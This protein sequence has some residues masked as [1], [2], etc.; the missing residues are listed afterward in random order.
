MSHTTRLSLGRTFYVIWIFYFLSFIASYA[1]LPTIPLHLRELG[2]SVKESGRFTTA[3]MLGAGFGALVTGP[4]GDRWGQKTILRW[5]T[6]I[7]GV[8]FASYAFLDKIWLFF[9]VGVPHGVI[10]SGYRTSTLALVGGFL[11]E[12]RRAEGFA[13]FGMAAPAGAALGPLLGIWLMALVGFSETML[14]IAALAASLVFI[15]GRL[16]DGEATQGR[17][18]APLE[19]DPPLAAEARAAQNRK[20]LFTPIVVLACIAISYGPLPSYGAQEAVDLNIRWA[21]ALMS[22]YGG[23]MV[24]LR[25]ILGWRGMGESPFRL[26]PFMLAVNV[27]AALGLAVMPGGLMRHILCGALFGASFG[28]AHTLIWAYA[29]GRAESK[30]R[31][32]TA[33][34]LYF[35]YDIGIGLGSLL[36]GF[37]MEHLGYRWGWGACAL[38]LCAAWLAGRK[39]IYGSRN[40]GAVWL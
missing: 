17:P 24:T 28:M 4:L 12:A 21:S 36:I 22:C 7:A 35:A 16:P 19:L 20:W 10:W 40:D 32:A 38:S 27:A 30:K 31:G 26:L 25:L 8:C 14:I 6:L 18:G 9:L 3:F 11:P 37:P 1:L 13:F 33:G 29:M 15:L 23:G 2:A 39:L 34:I 5:A